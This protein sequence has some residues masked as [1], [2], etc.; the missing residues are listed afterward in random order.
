MIEFFLLSVIIVFLVFFFK[1]MSIVF[2][3]LFIVFIDKFVNSLVWNKIVN[4]VFN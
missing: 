2:F 4:I 3:V 1:I